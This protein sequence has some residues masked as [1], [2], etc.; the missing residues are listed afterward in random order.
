MSNWQQNET[1]GLAVAIA[2]LQRE[3]PGWWWRVGNCHVS[4][5]ATIGPDSMGADVHL[6]HN[7]IFDAGIDGDLL[8]PT[9]PA[10]ALNR[11][12][13]LA[14]EAKMNLAKLGLDQSDLNPRGPR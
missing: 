6:L 13:D 10:A 8:H 3:L 11:A 2:R 9:T 4:A 7:R 14:L 5:D 1:D 12:I